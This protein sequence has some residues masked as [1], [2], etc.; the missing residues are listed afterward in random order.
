MMVCRV[1]EYYIN[2]AARFSD[3]LFAAFSQ[4]I[5]GG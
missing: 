2:A 4:T 1:F 3:G 5:D